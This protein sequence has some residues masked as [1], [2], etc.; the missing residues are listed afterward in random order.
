MLY[1]REKCQFSN[2]S[3]LIASQCSSLG[4]GTILT[5]SLTVFLYLSWVLEFSIYFDYEW[6]LCK[7]RLREENPQFSLPT[8]SGNIFHLLLNSVYLAFFTLSSFFFYFFYFSL[9]FFILFSLSSICLCLYRQIS[10][11]LCLLF[12]FFIS[13]YLFLYLSPSYIA[14]SIYLFSSICSPVSFFLSVFLSLHLFFLCLSSF[15]DCLSHSHSLSLSLYLS[16]STPSI[17]IF[18]WCL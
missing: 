12:C 16:V 4:P 10:W 5:I 8:I 17:Y 2:C 14:F 13:L 18:W 7:E 3:D 11:S 6:R 1:A 9:F 15:S